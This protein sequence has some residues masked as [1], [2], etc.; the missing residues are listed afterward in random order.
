MFG[1]KLCALV[2]AFFA[3]V[4]GDAYAQT[5][6]DSAA[7]RYRVAKP[8][9]TPYEPVRPAS[10][11]GLK[12]PSNF[13]NEVEY[14]EETDQYIIHQKV[15]GV[16]VR[17]PFTM[18]R[19]EYGD[20]DVNSSLKNYWRQRYRNESFERQGGSL[21]KFNVDNELFE[22]I[23]GSSVI[24]IKP[25]GTASLKFGLKITNT[26]NPNI[27]QSLRRQTIFDFK[28]NIQMSVAGKIGDNLEMKISYDT[29]SQFDFDNTINLKFQ[30]KEDDIIQKIEAGNV[31][32]P[33]STSLITGSQSLFGVLTELKFGKLYVST[34]I[35]QQKG[36]SKTITTQ[37]GAQVSQFDVSAVDY[38]KNRHFFLSH[39]FRSQ[40]D[41]ALKH[42]PLIV[43]SVQITKVEVW[44]TNTK[45][46]TE[47]A[48]NIV[49]FMDLGE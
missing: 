19:E 5:A 47:N 40:Y 8:A 12:D 35:S 31:S 30:G 43:S 36:E 18:S 34:V 7:L 20:Y 16:D 24:D 46:S 9:A 10:N 6:R 41:K 37:G 13:T 14:D 21:T 44:V 3:I 29:E 42:L 25:Q 39:Y 22:T 45:R 48:H 4:V 26:A 11:I 2:V 32:L 28:E 33:L 1:T 49:A 27:A 23:F 17:P 38:D 15:G